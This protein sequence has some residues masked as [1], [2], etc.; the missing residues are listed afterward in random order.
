MYYYQSNNTPDRFNKSPDHE[1]S[2]KPYI[3]DGGYVLPQ[4]DRNVAFGN[5][6]PTMR[7]QDTKKTTD[8][9]TY[10]DTYDGYTLAR[11]SGFLTDIPTTD[12]DGA[13]DQN[14]NGNTTEK[15]KKGLSTL[16]KLMISF[17]IFL[18]LAMGGVCAYI[19]MRRQGTDI[20]QYLLR[21]HNLYQSFL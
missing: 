15:T 20:Y 17:L 2:S 1:P 3:R 16:E 18:I 10:D 6:Q 5:Q 9:D 21:N 14:R 7:P 13:N 8:G 4:P 11:N 19:V 12:Q